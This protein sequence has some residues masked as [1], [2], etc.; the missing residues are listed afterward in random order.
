ML[1]LNV[2]NLCPVFISDIVCA[3]ICL[4]PGVIGGIEA[5]SQETSSWESLNTVDG[6]CQEEPLFSGTHNGLFLFIRRM[7]C[8]T[9][10]GS[11]TQCGNL[12][13]FLFP[14]DIF[15][16]LIKENNQLRI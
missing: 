1:P 10:L 15:L 6:Q 7:A 16:C 3:V 11:E 8:F 14:F 5:D 2:E 9:L 13:T 12:K 4:Q